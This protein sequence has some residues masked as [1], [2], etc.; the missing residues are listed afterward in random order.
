MR[1]AV[2]LLAMACVSAWGEATASPNLL[3]DGDFETA[4]SSNWEKRTPDG[5]ER[6]LAIISGGAHSGERFARIVNRQAAISRWRQGADQALR[7]E[8]GSVVRLSGWIRTELGAEGYA[9]LRLYCMGERDEILSQ[10]QA[11][12]V[13]G[14]SDWKRNSLIARIPQGTRHAMVYLE[15]QNAAGTA[16]FDDV[17]LSLVTAAKPAIRRD[18]I[19]LLTDLEGDNAVVRDFITLYPE[20]CVV[21]KPSEAA[22]LNGYKAVVIFIREPG[23]MP[24]FDRLQEFARSGGSVV[25]D[26]RTYAR[27]RSVEARE[28]RSTEE[29][30]LRIRERHGAAR[31]FEPGDVIPWG[32]RKEGQWAQTVLIGK[33]PGRI[34]GESLSG[35]TLLMAE[36]IGKGSLLATDLLSL[37][38]P[39]YNQ[40]G[41]FNKYLFAANFIG[42][43]AR[44]GRHF[45]R[46]LSYTEFVGEMRKL[47]AGTPGVRI[48]DEG[49]AHGDTR[50]FSL[51]IGDA[52]KPA[53]LIYAATHGSEWEP[54]YGLL[55][56]ARLLASNG[57]GAIY[58]KDRYRVKLIPILNPTGYDANTRKNAS[59][60]DLNRNGG[61]WWDAFRGRDSDKDGVAGPG[62]NDWKG[63]G[64]FS[65][66]EARTLRDVC[67]RT[68]LRAALDFHGN[69]GGRG[70]NRLVILPLTGRDDNEERVD[71]AVRAFNEAIRDRFIFQEANRPG[72]QQYE[73]EAMQFDSERPT[74]IHTVCKNGYG[75]LCEVPAGYRGTYG[76]VIQTEIVIETCLAFFDA[77]RR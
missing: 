5:P 65:E 6:A 52:Q 72:V 23:A 57:G 67:A 3:K 11:R 43:G 70:N 40:P 48:E 37:P 27:W 38:E 2:G 19:L 75:F 22:S 35:G 1:I 54:A 34:V 63:A 45:D 10:P 51:N 46:R 56:L 47:A 14:K 15:L 32:Y 30:R 58:D 4:P 55:T 44:H 50:V 21:R 69:A 29:T 18:D 73:I 33:M 31:G 61:E 36:D 17:S 64:P 71:A 74:L 9:A 24:D 66:N 49:P 13:A 25:M 53:F 42:S 26:L 7:L 60:V 68:P 8:P 62:D 20:R 59:A 39:I 41:S 76:L 77:Y 16:D 12:P 28:V